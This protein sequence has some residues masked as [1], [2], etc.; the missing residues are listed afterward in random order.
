[1]EKKICM[2]MTVYKDRN[3]KMIKYLGSGQSSIPNKVSDII[4]LKQDNDPCDDYE[5]YCTLSNISVLSCDATS[6]NEKRHFGY[7]WAID[8]G[9]D[10]LIWI[11]DD[12]RVNVCHSDFKTRVPSGYWANL[13]V[14]IDGSL[15]RM[16][17]MYEEHD[18]CGMIANYKIGFL[19]GSKKREYKNMS[20]HPGGFVLI[21]L[22]NTKRYPEIDYPTSTDWM[23]DIYFYLTMLGVGVPVYVMGDYTINIGNMYFKPGTNKS[24]A[25]ADEDGGI[26]K[27]DKQLIRQYLKFGGD[28]YLYND[29]LMNKYKHAKYFNTKDQLPIPYGKKFDENL[30]GLCKSREVDDELANEVI[31]YLQEKKRKKKEEH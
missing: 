1:M 8:N 11:D 10:A 19:C 4:I 22:N 16:L 17:E 20:C 24:L 31:S 14:P 30:M 28:L 15:D 3:N 6:I 29:H 21:N 18:D 9:Y 23:E 27:R 13:S 2:M 7:H 25:Y 12:I 26:T 5:K